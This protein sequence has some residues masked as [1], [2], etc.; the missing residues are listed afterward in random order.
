LG[1]LV[2]VGYWPRLAKVL[3]A[4]MEEISAM[5]GKFSLRE[6]ETV[7]VS[8]ETPEIVPMV[9]RG[10]SCLVGKL[11]ADRIIPKEF[12]K[13]PL[14][15]AWKPAG[16]ASFNVIGENMFI[17]EFENEWDKARIMEGRPWL[18]DGNLVSLAEFDGLTPPAKINF[19][20][21]SFWIRMYNL[22]LACMGRNTGQKIGATVGV[23]EDVDVLEEDA[24]W[25]EY[26]RVRILID[27]TKPL[28]RGRML[29]LQDR[30]TW[31]AFK[32]E[33]LPKFCFTCGLIKHDSKGCEKDGG[34]SKTGE[35][36]EQ[37]YGTWLRV[38]FPQ[39]RGMGG[40]NPY[41]GYRQEGTPG[42]EQQWRAAGKAKDTPP[43]SPPV[44]G[45]GLG[46]GRTISVPNPS[47][48]R[49]D[50]AMESEKIR[51]EDFAAKNASLT[52]GRNSG[53]IDGEFKRK[54]GRALEGKKLMD[55]DVAGDLN[56][57]GSG[58]D[59]ELDSIK[60]RPEGKK[61]KQFLGRWDSDLG[62]MVY[63]CVD[64][65]FSTIMLERDPCSDSYYPRV[66]TS[67]AE[68]GWAV[69]NLS[70]E[71]GDSERKLSEKEL[72]SSKKKGREM[73]T[74][75]Q[76]LFTPP[77]ERLKA[78]NGSV[79]NWKKRARQEAASTQSKEQKGTIGDGSKEDQSTVVEVDYQQRKGRK[80]VE[81]QLCCTKQLAVAVK[82][83]RQAQ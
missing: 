31:V 34:Q 18:F 45:Q 50:P 20:R 53:E 48:P 54:E 69:P 17:V 8:L 9:N 83:P 23:V 75:A 37:Q 30:S 14:M 66:V 64:E 38:Q 2:E 32:Y 49:K 15:R 51:R 79:S 16:S 61:K 33:K 68:K 73:S 28:A 5:W 24:G 43:T 72:T 78:S 19:D 1:N 4:V 57:E 46:G 12:Y 63:E 56:M 47:A 65:D 60:E 76:A 3:L 42:D 39:R 6:E 10:R 29:H 58:P 81:G 80:L 22:P 55:E 35:T 67:R 44:E 74:E 25:G 59:G 41:G 27:L 13:T 52:V 26:L 21:A 77:T 40:E 82:Q 36:E 7:G 62:Q 71:R 70:E 11:V